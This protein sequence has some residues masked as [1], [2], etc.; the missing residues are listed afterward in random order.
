MNKRIVYI[1][2]CLAASLCAIILYRSAVPLIQQLDLR[3]KDARFRLRGPQRPDPRVVVV[4]ID[5]KSV[6][7]LGRWPWSREVTA[8]LITALKGYG[9]RI[10]ALDIV[11]SEPQGPLP[12]QRLA[13]AVGRSGN[14]VLGY[15]F[16]QE[17]QTLSSAAHE[18]LAASRIR[19]LRSEKGA[20]FPPIPEFPSLDAT[21]PRVGAKALACGFFN[22]IPDDDGLCRTIPLLALY[23]GAVYPSLA[24]KALGLYLG[25]EPRV[26]VAPFGI[27][28]LALNDLALPVGE[29]GSLALN[30]Y[31]PGGSF[32]TLSAVDVLNRRV[33]TGVLRNALVF[34]GATEAGI[35]DLRATPFDPV[36]P[37]VEIHATVAANALEGRFL[38]RNSSTVALE[39]GAIVLVPLLLARL[40]A[41]SS[42]T[43]AG[44]G[45]FAFSVAGYLLAN[46]YVFSYLAWDLS[47]I[48][49]LVPLFAGYT[50]CEAYR[51][52]VIEKRGRYL[53]SAFG[54]Y[55]SPD[56]VE[57]I[58]KDPDRLRLGGERREITVLFSDIRAFTTISES[59]QPEDLVRLLNGYLS[60]MT[61]IILEERGTLDKYIGDAV[62]AIFNAPLDVANHAEHAC[63]TAFRMLD[64]LTTL[65]AEFSSSG[66]PEIDIGIG[67][68]T[69]DAIVGN[70]GADIRFDYTAIGDNVNLASRLEGLNKYYGTRILVTSATRHQAGD[71][72][73]FREA[74]LVRV[75]GK[76]EPVTV[77]ELMTSRHELAAPFSRGLSLYRER[78]FAEAAPLFAE[79]NGRFGDR[80]SLLY[81]ERCDSFLLAPPPAD[82]DGVCTLQAK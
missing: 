55:V 37:G 23:D 22:V 35:A 51:N 58:V 61:R 21:I 36:M 28:T 75:K 13:D 15:F 74:D 8:G 71:A 69:G 76:R 52:L 82:W 17:P 49:P 48:F 80:L 33:A 40:L 79:L 16:R 57:V 78:R 65:N 11:F 14:V 38:V 59:L 50:G 4:A 29:G 45:W 32:V 18:Q 81:Q 19:L 1:L 67:I 2:I 70:M 44:L 9:V 20:S 25:K 24:L 46:L 77:F 5:N 7:E 34:V 47:V 68:N 66:L 43:L 6:K 12:D 63:R 73:L 53:K 62:M 3:L 27:R 54:S 41:S 26:E 64:R 31:G 56:L 10:T 42:G 72:F 60:P 39:I 30:Y